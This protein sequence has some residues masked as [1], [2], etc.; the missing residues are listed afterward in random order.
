MW[1]L[2]AGADKT[3]EVTARSILVLSA[4]ALCARHGRDSARSIGAQPG[5]A[6]AH[7][8]DK[9]TA[10]KVGGH[11]VSVHIQAIPMHC[12]CVPMAFIWRRWIAPGIPETEI[13]RRESP[14]A[15]GFPPLDA[16]LRPN[17][18]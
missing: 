13:T 15:E 7:G 16:A 8:G 6:K 3:I 12:N 11:P 17:F 5:S 9:T 14:Y 18:P 2:H 4:L 1:Q 10:G